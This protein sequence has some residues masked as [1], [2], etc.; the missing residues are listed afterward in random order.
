MM[1]T[2]KMRESFESKWGYTNQEQGLQFIPELNVYGCELYENA[3]VACN[4]SSAWYYWQASRAAIEVE[5]PLA[6]MPVEVD[7][8]SDLPLMQAGAV[9]AAIES[10]GL[11]V[12]P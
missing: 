2:E 11:K 9:I 7:H 12:K 6:L 8:H 4:K 1:S 10:L 5:L 3:G